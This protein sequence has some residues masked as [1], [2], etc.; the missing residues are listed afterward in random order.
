MKSIIY[1]ECVCSRRYSA[2]NAHAP[3]C[4]R[5]PARLYDIFHIISQT[6]RFSKKKHVL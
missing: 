3:Y 1:S 5:W 4:H 2:C 6:E